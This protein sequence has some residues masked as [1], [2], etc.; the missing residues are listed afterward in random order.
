MAFLVLVITCKMSLCRR[1]TH[2]K[3]SRYLQFN[4]YLQKYGHETKHLS[5]HYYDLHFYGHL[6][7]PFLC[8]SNTLCIQLTV[9]ISI[10]ITTYSCISALFNELAWLFLF[11]G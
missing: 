11:N 8:F 5:G 4:L 10:A 7:L 1:K 9:I 6:S 3:F 2:Q